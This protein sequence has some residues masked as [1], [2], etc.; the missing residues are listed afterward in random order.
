L[1]PYLIDKRQCLGYFINEK[2]FNPYLKI[3]FACNLVYSFI[4]F[5]SMFV[6][7]RKK[8][9]NSLSPFESFNQLFLL[10][11]AEEEEANKSLNENLKSHL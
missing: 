6:S 1:V 3:V 11:T 8:M 5:L 10:L 2:E 4:E 7:V 9:T